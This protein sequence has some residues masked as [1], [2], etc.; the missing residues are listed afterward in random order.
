MLIRGHG[1]K[2]AWRNRYPLQAERLT[3][4]PQIFKWATPS[5][6][7]SRE[8]LEMSKREIVR[9]VN[10]PPDTT[11]A[12][13]VADTCLHP[14][15]VILGALRLGHRKTAGC[16]RAFRVHNLHTAIP[17]LGPVRTLRN[18]Q[19]SSR[20]KIQNV[21]LRPPRGLA[22]LMLGILATAAR[23][24]R[25]PTLRTDDSRSQGDE[26]RRAWPAR[27]TWKRDG[28]QQK[29][30]GSSGRSGPISSQSR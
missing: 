27:D 25:P 18:F 14:I 4:A 20:T 7:P 23:P 17:P 15:Q 1:I 10:W 21:K 3:L 19:A 26:D 9:L 22:R 13:F 29:A 12:L 5:S 8:G 16:C 28:Q 30:S 6:E 11:F 2:P 24:S